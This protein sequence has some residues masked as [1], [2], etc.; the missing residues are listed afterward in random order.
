MAVNGVRRLKMSKRTPGSNPNM[1]GFR[2]SADPKMTTNMAG[3]AKVK[4][5]GFVQARKEGDPKLTGCPQ[6]R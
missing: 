3:G 5:S 6:A 4:F 1:P 2:E